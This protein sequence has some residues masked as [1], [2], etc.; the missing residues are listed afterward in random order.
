MWCKSGNL[1][2]KKARSD[3]DDG[4]YETNTAQTFCWAVGRDFNLTLCFNMFTPVF[5]L[6]ALLSQKLVRPKMPSWFR[7]SGRKPAQ[8]RKQVPFI[9]FYDTCHQAH[10]VLLGF[11]WGSLIVMSQS[12]KKHHN[13]WSYNG[14]I[15]L[16][17]KGSMKHAMVLQHDVQEVAAGTYLG[18]TYKCSYAWCKKSFPHGRLDF[19]INVLV[20]WSVESSRLCQFLYQFS[21]AKAKAANSKYKWSRCVVSSTRQARTALKCFNFIKTR[22]LGMWEPLHKR[23]WS[24]CSWFYMFDMFVYVILFCNMLKALH[25]CFTLFQG[26][27]AANEWGFPRLIFTCFWRR[28]RERGGA[29]CR[30]AY[31]TRA[32]E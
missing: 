22:K 15:I 10:K 18:I 3:F 7:T 1:K 9:S 11:W 19:V 31:E 28:Y 4:I 24:T 5:Y 13:K 27:V 12:V 23:P 8:L 21:V 2:A 20:F 16:I 14:R 6:K 32:F 25:V 26:L 29:T 30:G 17:W